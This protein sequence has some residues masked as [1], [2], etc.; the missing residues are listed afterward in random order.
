MPYSPPADRFSKDGKVCRV[1]CVSFVALGSE[2]QPGV[3]SHDDIYLLLKTLA[4]TVVLLSYGMERCEG[5]AAAQPSLQAARQGHV[6]NT[7]K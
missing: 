2:L 7:H 6:L 5:L 4:I 1:F 3:A